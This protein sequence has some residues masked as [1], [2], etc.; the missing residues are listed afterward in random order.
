MKFHLTS[1]IFFC[2]L[3]SVIF[4]QNSDV[5][6]LNTTDT[7]QWKTFSA[8]LLQKT[9]Y[10]QWQNAEAKNA[11][12]FIV[13]KSTDG[14]NF[15][16]IG[17]MQAGSKST[18]I[19]SLTDVA[20]QKGSHF[21]RIRSVANDNNY[22]DSPVKKI[23]AGERQAIMQL[24]Q[25]PVIGNSM[26]VVILGQSGMPYTVRIYNAQAKLLLQKPAG[27]GSNSIDLSNL[28]AGLYLA[29][30]LQNDQPAGERL[31]VVKK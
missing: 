27:N 21:Y 4:D 18:R 7:V 20:P 3:T 2:L 22:T 9:V 29:E 6:G 30:L 8:S 19:Y 10:L 13:E 16:E 31:W 5:A 15:S 25:N 17:R 1:A 14:I 23:T 28:T 11:S 26:Q 12:F 24:L